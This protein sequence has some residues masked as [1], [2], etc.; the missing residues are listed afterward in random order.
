MDFTCRV[1][2]GDWSDAHEIDPERVDESVRTRPALGS[3]HVSRSARREAHPPRATS[4]R[5]ARASTQIDRDLGSLPVRPRQDQPLLPAARC[6]RSS[7]GDC[8]QAIEAANAYYDE[9]PEDLL[10]ILA[11]SAKAKAETAARATSTPRSET[12]ALAADLM[13]SIGARAALPR[14]RLPPLA[15]PARRRR[16]RTRAASG[17]GAASALARA[18]PAGA[19]GRRCGARA[20]VAWR[21][22]EVLRLAGRHR[23]LVGDRRAAHAPAAAQSRG[24]AG[25]RRRAGDRADATKSWAVRLREGRRRR[26]RASR[27]VLDA[28]ALLR[29]GAGALPVAGPGRRPRAPRNPKDPFDPAAAPDPYECRSPTSALRE[30]RCMSS[31]PR[32]RPSP[33][34]A[35]P[36]VVALD[37]APAPPRP[38]RAATTSRARSMCFAPRRARSRRPSRSR[39]RRCRSACAPRCATRAR[40][41][42][43]CAAGVRRRRRGPRHADLRAARRRARQRRGAGARAA[44]ARRI[45]AR[46]SRASRPGRV[47]SGPGGTRDLPGRSD[48]S[49]SYA[50]SIG[51]VAGVST[52]LP[53]PDGDRPDAAAPEHADRPDADRGRADRAARFRPDSSTTRCA[54][55]V[56]TS[57]HDRL[58]R[59]A[60]S[61]ST[62][63]ARRRP[64]AAI[65]A[66]RSFTALPVPNDFARHGGPTPARRD[67]R[68]ASR[69]T[70]AGN[71]L[72]P[73]HWSGVLC[74]TDADCSFEGFPPP[75]LVQVLFPQSLGSGLDARG[76][77]RRR[78]AARSSIPSS[79]FTSSHTLQGTELPADL[80][81]VRVD[82]A[83]AALRSSGRPTR[84]RP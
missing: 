68:C 22:T 28:A 73:M 70:R 58:H 81:P 31:L 27:G 55:A 32:E 11:L 14:Q 9:N 51:I 21:R 26:W 45:P 44:E 33:G 50:A 29:A 52:R 19:R 71:V 62:A 66:S 34:L 41:G 6:C 5:R 48:S 53:L 40:S 23:W 82:A 47:S 30:A 13:A 65:R 49:M 10:H 20:K 63:P 64:R 37:R 83:A 56:A 77:T 42:L 35:I 24:G 39:V 69:S 84:C 79:E 38:A 1:L 46:C 18:A 2:E 4:T 8:A 17:A 12:L 3:D 61:A 67:P 16:A 15:A 78:R 25:A 60:L 74:Q 7:S 76:A 43:G 36:P 80:R 59:R 54:D 72:A 75:Q 57:G